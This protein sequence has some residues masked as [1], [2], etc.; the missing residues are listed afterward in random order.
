MPGSN[1][2]TDLDASR[3]WRFGMWWGQ[4]GWWGS[5]THIPRIWGPLRQA[6]LPRHGVA[7]Q[8]PLDCLTIL[9]VTGGSLNKWGQF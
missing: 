1:L 4:G 6:P 2:D 7:G 9:C 5:A 8:C 3:G